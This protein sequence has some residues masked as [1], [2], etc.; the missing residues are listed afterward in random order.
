MNQIQHGNYGHIPSLCLS[1]SL[2]NYGTSPSLWIGSSRLE[3]SG[4]DLHSHA[5]LDL[6]MAIIT[7]GFHL[8][9]V[10]HPIALPKT[11]GINIDAGAFSKTKLG[12]VRDG[13]WVVILATSFVATGG[14]LQRSDEFGI[15]NRSK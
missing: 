11:T 6:K 2:A 4:A 1:S 3:C 14:K 12:I 13:M 8:R 10:D 5:L 7:A 15:S 9:L